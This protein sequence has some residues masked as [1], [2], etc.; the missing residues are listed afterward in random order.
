MR[1]GGIV[2]SFPL[3]PW[4]ADSQQREAIATAVATGTTDD[5]QMLKLRITTMAAQLEPPFLFDPDFTM[6]RTL[7]ICFVDP[8]PIRIYAFL[9]AHLPGGLRSLL[10][11][12]YYPTSF[13][14]LRIFPGR[15][16]PGMFALIGTWTSA[17]SLEAAKP[18]PA[19]RVLERFQR[20]LAILVT[21]CGSF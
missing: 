1:K 14:D 2:T 16:T 10:A 3:C 9:S 17:D 6:V 4:S 11:E 5:G 8:D 19:F 21:D 7:T 20:N 13:L 12:E 15:E 18:T